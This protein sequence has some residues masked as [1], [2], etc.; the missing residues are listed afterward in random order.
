MAQN[1]S[2]KYTKTETVQL[3]VLLEITF[4]HRSV[5]LAF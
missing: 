3:S 2:N 5:F 4:I 1:A